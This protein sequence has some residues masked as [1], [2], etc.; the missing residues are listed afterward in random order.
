MGKWDENMA[1]L[2]SFQFFFF[3]SHNFFYC[4]L[5]VSVPDSPS[6]C[7]SIVVFYIVNG[8]FLPFSFISRWWL[9][10][11][12]FYNW[13]LF[14]L[15][16]RDP[17]VILDPWDPPELPDCLAPQH[18]P[19]ECP[20]A[21][22]S[23]FTLASRRAPR[24]AVMEE[25]RDPTSCSK[26]KT[27]ITTI[28]AF[29]ILLFRWVIVVSVTAE[30]IDLVLHHWNCQFSSTSYSWPIAFASKVICCIFIT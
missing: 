2:C 6:L 13:R 25:R 15:F 22:Q 3:V 24:H 29:F 27:T 20:R 9:M 28:A 19:V 12:C 11:P 16:C 21:H 14:L 18:H 10:Y 30:R 26:T 8:L 7:F 23:A 1:P 5:R 4:S 17:Q